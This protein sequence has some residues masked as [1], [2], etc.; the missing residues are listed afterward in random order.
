MEGTTSVEVLQLVFLQMSARD[1]ARAC[2]CS[3]LWNEVGCSEDLW[4]GLCME[5]WPGCDRRTVGKKAIKGMG[6][7][8][9]FYSKRSLEEKDGRKG[10]SLQWRAWRMKR[11]PAIA[12]EEEEE[13]LCGEMSWED[14]TFFVDLRYKGNVVVSTAISG[15][16]S[17]IRRRRRRRR[18]RRGSSEGGGGG[19]EKCYYYW[20]VGD[21]DDDDDDDEMVGGTGS[22]LPRHA[23]TPCVYQGELFYE[24]PFQAGHAAHYSLHWSAVRR[25]DGRITCLLRAS[26]DIRWRQ[27]QDDLRPPLPPH[28]AATSTLPLLFHSDLLTY[29]HHH[30][31]HGHDDHH[32]HHDDHDH[33][34]DHGHDDHDLDLDI[35]LDHGHDHHHHVAELVSFAC[36]QCRPVWGASLSHPMRLQFVDLQLG[37]WSGSDGGTSPEA[38][39]LLLLRKHMDWH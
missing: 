14:L 35:D 34:H 4:R 36:L 20:R 21:G 38:A 17:I 15:G 1:L 2:C 12:E 26:P 3:K 28:L 25:S 9:L 13:G 37:L 19:R 6:G 10:S 22:V 39:L 33:D 16:D 32:H 29:S 5:K 31:D 11:C 7:Y 8:R 30:H 18:R 24:L 27:E 23:L